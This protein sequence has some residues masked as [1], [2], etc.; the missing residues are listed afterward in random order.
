M[1]ISSRFSK[2]D[3]KNLT[4][5]EFMREATFEDIITDYGKRF[6][7]AYLARESTQHVEQ[8]K[9]LNIQI[10]QL[11]DF[12]SKHNH[13]VLK[14]ECKFVEQGKSGLSTNWRDTFKLMIDM[15]RRE[16]F[17]ILVVDSVSRFARNVG[18]LFTTIDTLKEMGVGVLVL[19]GYYWTFNMTPTDLLRLA[20]EAGLA[21][22]ESM[23][24]SQRVRK[25]MAT[26]AQNGQLLCSSLF[27]YRLIKQVERK[28]NTF[29]IEKSEAFTV[30]LIFEKYA[31][32]DPDVH[33]STVGISNYLRKNNFLTPTGDLRW[34]PSKIN[35]IL[36]N[37]K[38]M[39]Y[40]LYGK[41]KV[42]DPIKKKKVLTGIQ[43]IPD[44]YDPDGKLV[45]KGNLVKGNWA[46]IISEELWWKA[47]NKL[48]TTKG[49]PT[50]E[51]SCNGTRVSNDA[52]ARKA[53]C[54]CGYTLT[55]QAEHTARADK[56]AQFRYKCRWQINNEI[57]KR[58]GLLDEIICDRPAI[59]EMKMWLQ[60]LR[61]FEY[62]F[63][64]GKDAVKKTLRLIEECRQ[65]E[66]TMNSDLTL[67]ALEDELEKRRKRLKAYIVMKADGEISSEE[68]TEVYHMT[69]A[70]IEDLTSKLSAYAMEQAKMKKKILNME[71]IEKRLNSF[72]DLSGYKVSDEMIEIFVE[73]IIY[74][75]KDEFVWV[76]NLSEDATGSDKNYRIK[77]YD[78]DYEKMLMNDSQFNIVARFT[79]SVDECAD[80]CR[81][82]LNRRF[83]SRY[84][85]DI[86]VKIAVV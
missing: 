27:G 46:P 74:R 10:Q 17:E 7:V 50:S 44:E 49:F 42:V 64:S 56:G 15:A 70:E 25:H 39:G 40:S 62:L 20:T 76:I 19:T 51:K 47:N 67:K 35:R 30:K 23:Q 31:S 60:S 85:Q 6:K 24:T 32:D 54:A 45:K 29:E 71:S 33:M 43:P 21:Q 18:E 37:E 84:W 55:P 4:S 72:I 5:V 14:S 16:S 59:S 1:S 83:F 77:G 78:P 34:T 58:E 28:D 75:G 38:Y 73:R 80:Y 26:V 81:N 57:H 65:T 8:V 53:F 13:F 2:L 66:S 22:A 48:R 63:S 61:V 86:T 41:S 68:Y 82:T 79:I 69:N 11:E 3:V 36:K 12:I 52:I 9:A